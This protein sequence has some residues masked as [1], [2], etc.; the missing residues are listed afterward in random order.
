MYPDR[1]TI[2]QFLPARRLC[3]F[4]FPIRLFK[5]ITKHLMYGPRETVS[6]VFPRVL[7]FP[8]TKHEGNIRTLG[9]TKLTISLGAIH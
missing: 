6:I 4:A 9:K 8:E 7:M 5:Y 3:L 2:V 1:D